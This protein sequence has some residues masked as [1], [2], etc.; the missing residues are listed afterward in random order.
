MVATELCLWVWQGVVVCLLHTAANLLNFWAK[1]CYIGGA[2]A[3]QA[4]QAFFF[5]G[6]FPTHDHFRPPLCFASHGTTPNNPQT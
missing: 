6:P 5:L 2:L 3:C 4:W 1:P